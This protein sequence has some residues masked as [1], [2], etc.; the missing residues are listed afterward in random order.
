MDK[1]IIR[2]R[3]RSFEEEYVRKYDA[4]LI[5]KLRERGRLEEIA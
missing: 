2:E 5:E 4:K 1:D 3:A